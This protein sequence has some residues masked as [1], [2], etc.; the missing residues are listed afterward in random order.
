MSD[1]WRVTALRQELKEAE[2]LIGIL[3]RHLETAE[4]LVADEPPVE[5]L[6]VDVIVADKPVREVASIMTD[7]EK[8]DII[9]RFNAG[10][11][12]GDIAIALDRLKQTVEKHLLKA[13]IDPY[14]GVRGHRSREAR[15]MQ[16]RINRT[17]A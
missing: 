3:W 13:G 1:D 4:A 6:S 8:A 10:Q 5:D 9:N 12:C 2:I 16:N 11:S 15:L 7:V 17:M 14:R